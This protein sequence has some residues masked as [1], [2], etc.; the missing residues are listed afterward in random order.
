MLRIRPL[1]ACE[2]YEVL[3]IALSTISA[4]LKSMKNAGIIKDTKEGRWVIYDLVRGRG[5]VDRLI[6]SIAE[7]LRDEPIVKKDRAK[8]S[9]ITREICSSKFQIAK[10]I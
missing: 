6:D 3:N 7:E 9:M 4:H 1:C 5:Y 8:I 2:I 10:N